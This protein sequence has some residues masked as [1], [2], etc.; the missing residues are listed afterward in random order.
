MSATLLD[1]EGKIIERAERAEQQ[2]SF[3]L[4][5]F[6]SYLPKGQYIFRPTRECWV[7]GSVD[8]KVSWPTYSKPDGTE[9]KMRPTNW[10]DRNRSV[11]QMTWA[12]GEPE[13]IERKYLVDGGWIDW[14]GGRCLNL[15]IPAPAIVDGEARLARPWLDH[16]KLVYPD[17]YEHIV[18]WLA[19]RVQRPQEKINHALVLGG[20]PGIGKDSLLEPV[21]RAIGHWNFQ[22]VSPKQAYGRF[23]GF[24]KGVILRIS[25]ARDLGD[26]DRFTFYEAMKTYIA[27]PPDVLRCDEKNLKEHAILNVCG[28]IITTNYKTDGIYLPPTDRRHYVTWSELTDESVCFTDGYWIKLW[29]WYESGGFA[30]VARFLSE[31]DISRFDPKAPPPKTEA[32]WAI[33]DANRAPEEAEIADALDK[34]GD[35]EAVTIGMLASKASLEFGTW[36]REKRN[37]RAISHKME[38]CGYASVRNEGAKDGLWKVGTARMAVYAKKSLPQKNRL[39]AVESVKSVK[40]V[41]SH[42]HQDGN[43]KALWDDPP[44]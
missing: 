12:P 42:P 17:Y 6:W 29:S 10:L 14:P 7:G 21:K 19:H 32:F 8:T 18:D 16:V 28:V 9:G 24:I 34:L 39:L 38:K 13:M 35:P 20:E 37:H 30:H 11:E 2:D 22:E 25:E 15:Y 4:E 23:N 27:A 1:L 36:L 44:F 31:R 3:S 33:V 40:S 26:F 41:K 5:D 43:G